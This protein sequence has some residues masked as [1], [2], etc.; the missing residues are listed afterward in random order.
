MFKTSLDK[1]GLKSTTLGKI[2]NL[3]RKNQTLNSWLD[4]STTE[5]DLGVI[6]VH[7]LN[8]SQRCYAVAKKAG[9]TLG[10]LTGVNCPPSTLHFEASA[11]VLCLILSP[12]F[13]KDVPKLERVQR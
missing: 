11:E 4:G 10:V 5:K 1:L 8:L 7:K 6:L 13:K 9:I 2:L 12:F 3:G